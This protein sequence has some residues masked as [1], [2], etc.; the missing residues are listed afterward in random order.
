M[1]PSTAID[2]VDAAAVR[3]W[4][5]TRLRPRGHGVCGEFAEQSA[6]TPLA[7]LATFSGL[8]PQSP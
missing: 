1:I 6:R 2:D 3:I 7:P 8:L 4:A 5:Q